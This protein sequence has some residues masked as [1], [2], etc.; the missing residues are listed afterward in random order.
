MATAIKLEIMYYCLCY[1]YWQQFQWHWRI[2]I[3]KKVTP[4]QW[5]YAN[6][7]CCLLLKIHH[8]GELWFLVTADQSSQSN[9]QNSPFATNSYT[10]QWM[11]MI[12]TTEGMST[13]LLFHC[14]AVTLPLH[15]QHR[16]AVWTT[17]ERTDEEIARK[18][19]FTQTTTPKDPT[20]SLACPHYN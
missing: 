14:Y 7:K 10:V 17:R 11:T 13:M 3:N 1:Y 19:S 18:I 8:T 4:C 20:L 5:Y 2:I 9:I 15:P 12:S 6:T 16:H